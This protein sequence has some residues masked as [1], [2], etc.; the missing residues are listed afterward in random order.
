M[1]LFPGLIFSGEWDNKQMEVS[2][3]REKEGEGIGCDRQAWDIG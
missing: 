2:L 3:E 1:P